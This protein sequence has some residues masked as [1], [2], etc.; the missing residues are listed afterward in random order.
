MR[1]YILYDIRENMLKKSGGKGIYTFSHSTG[2]IFVV[3]HL[4][5]FLLAGILIAVL[6][7]YKG[8]LNPIVLICPV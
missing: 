8:N 7:V 5:K 4:G 3:D 6:A 1:S 2:Y